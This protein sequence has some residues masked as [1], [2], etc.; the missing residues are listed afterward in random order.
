M[1]MF[2][3]VGDKEAVEMA[4]YIAFGSL[5]NYRSGIRFGGRFGDQKL[6]AFENVSFQD[7]DRSMKPGIGV[8]PTDNRDDRLEKIVVPMS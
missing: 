1:F 4:G 6:F 8:I 5:M 3:E 7:Q 2:G